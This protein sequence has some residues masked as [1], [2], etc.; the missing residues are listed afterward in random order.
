MNPM[1]R[2]LLAAT[3]LWSWLGPAA[4]QEVVEASDMVR[5]GMQAIEMIDQGKAGELWDGA[6]PATR[7]RVTR[8]DFLGQVARSRAQIGVPQM[9]TWVSVNRQVV[10]AQDGDTAGQYVSIEYETRFA[11]KSD[12][13]VRELV[14]FHLDQDRVWRFS[15]YALK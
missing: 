2:L 11:S 8:A 10:A 12:G 15:G 3:L 9:R 5:G 14:S 13:T 7:K 6:A 4:A 1:I